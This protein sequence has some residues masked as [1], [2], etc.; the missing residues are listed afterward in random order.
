MLELPLP[1]G[2]SRACD[3]VGR[4]AC[5]LSF[6]CVCRYVDMSNHRELILVVW[7]FYCIVFLWAS[8]FYLTS[9]DPH[10]YALFAVSIIC[11]ASFW[12]I[13]WRLLQRK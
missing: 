7:A 3:V 4:A 10:G 13:Y 2:L 11:M 5:H 8:I 1:R 12:R 9:K 6:D